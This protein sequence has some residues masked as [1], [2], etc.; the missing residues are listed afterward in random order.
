MKP[1]ERVRK[2]NLGE[3]IDRVPFMPTL[4]EHCAALIHKT[5]SQAAQDKKLLVEAQLK[6]YETYG[7][8]LVTIGMDIYNVEVEALGAEILYTDTVNIPGMKDH[9]LA[10]TDELGHLSV[11]DP[12]QDGRMPMFLEAGEEIKKAIG[13]EVIVNGTIVGPFTMA[14]LLRGFEKIIFDMILN[15]EYA[16]TLMKFTADVGIRYA[17]AMI[18][19]GL[20]L[21]INESWITPPLMS[22]DLFKNQILKWEQYV[23][24]SLKE[25]GLTSIGL[26]SGGNTTPIL[27]DLVLSG[28]SLIMADY[29]CDLTY[30]K[31]KANE[32][33]ITLRGCIDS[34]ML[35][36]GT[37][38][39]I[40]KSTEEVLRIGM[41]GTG[42][43]V[44]GCGVVSYNTPTEKLRYFKKA[45]EEYTLR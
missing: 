2:M 17:E 9:I 4:Y 25:K 22:P 6:G 13:E 23:I 45:V 5:P 11:P 26:I 28:S 29:G 35:E 19:R 36:R 42:K 39:E 37:E 24:Q 14:A 12:E 3:S 40:R 31:Q 34:K 10:D 16:D 44:M 27:D 15:P 41:A 18:K 43:F 32:A 20:S 8:D 33:N 1:I 30:F 7:H 21:S 38:E